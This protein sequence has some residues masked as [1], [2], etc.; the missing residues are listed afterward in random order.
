[1]KQESDL[2]ISVKLSD[3]LK[4]TPEAA[5]CTEYYTSSL[6]SHMGKI[7]SSEDTKERD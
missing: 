6:I 1:L 3:C 4:K 7:E 5:N 2:R